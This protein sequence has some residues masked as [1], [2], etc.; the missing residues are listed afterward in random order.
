MSEPLGGGGLLLLVPLLLLVSALSP[1]ASIQTC[2]GSRDPVVIECNN[3]CVCQCTALPSPSPVPPLFLVFTQD[4]IYQ[5]PS[6]YSF[7]DVTA[8]G[9]GGGGSASIECQGNVLCS[10]EES[11]DYSGTQVLAEGAGGG[12][13]ALRFRGGIAVSGGQLITIEIGEGGEGGSM[14][15]QGANGSAGGITRVFLGLTEIASAG[16]GEGATT[17]CYLT[18]LQGQDPSQFRYLRASSTGGRAL[19]GTNGVR[20]Y[21]LSISSSPPLP[22]SRVALLDGFV[23]SGAGG[24]A[25]FISAICADGS[26]SQTPPQQGGASLR[27]PGGQPGALAGPGGGGASHFASGGAGS[28]LE[29]VGGPGGPGAGGGGG[30]TAG[31]RGGDGMVTIVLRPS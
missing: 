17:T 6:G 2:F 25:G 31:G 30:N 26:N 24:G 10:S 11:G 20:T 12:G 18:E 7:A 4:D 5:V 21:D 9:G 28:S 1:S 3:S 13:A 14:G 15:P 22:A 23:D 8:S 27:Y 16:G 29:G 19:G